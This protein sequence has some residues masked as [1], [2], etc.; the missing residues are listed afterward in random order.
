[1]TIID[2]KYNFGVPKSVIDSSGHEGVLD[3]VVNQGADMKD[4]FGTAIYDAAIGAQAKAPVIVC[5]IG[6]AV[7]SAS[8]VVTMS[9]RS[10]AA[11]ASIHSGGT[12]HVT[13]AFDAGASAKDQ[14]V[15]PIPA[16]GLNQYWGVCYK[17]SGA[18]CT[19]GTVYSYLAEAGEKNEANPQ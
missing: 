8:S 13:A 15:L 5:T 6:T 11:D 1:M 10:K 2:E 9:I 3:D 12:T 14:V 19:A 18:A 16:Q 4:A 17:I 7:L